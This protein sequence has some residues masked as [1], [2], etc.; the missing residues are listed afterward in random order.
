ML[1]NGLSPWHLMLVLA[2]VILVFGSKKL[3]D[4]ARG[5]GQSMRI[6]KA[7]SK[8]MKEDGK[9]KDAEATDNST[10]QQ[11][12]SEPAAVEPSR[13]DPPAA[14]AERRTENADQRPSA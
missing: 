6:L 14:T 4:V 9:K 10:A 7:E 3:P 11:T 2:V 13:I 5:L 1:S 8:A 12:S